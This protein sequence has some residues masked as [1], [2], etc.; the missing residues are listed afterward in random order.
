MIHPIAPDLWQVE[1]DLLMPGRLH[2]PCR[3]T[4][5]RLE[6][7][8]LL[9]LSP[10]RMDDKEAA[11]IAAIGPV[12]WIVAPNRMH[13]LWLGETRMRFPEAK[14]A[15]PP[16]LADK[17][18]DLHFDYVIQDG[19]GPWSPALEHVLIKGAP[20]VAE[21]VF[22]HRPSGTVLA[23]DLVMNIRRAR[24]AISPMVYRLAGTWGKLAQS[25]TWRLATR[26]RQL[27][28]GSVERIL[29]WQIHRVVPAH[30]D[31]VE[32]DA[33]ATLAAALRWMRSPRA[34]TGVH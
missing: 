6:D 16:G 13:H 7:S 25:R 1:T 5:V 30:G 21:V 18:P 8:S 14:L 11:A 15:G 31:V 4:I 3:M 17:R 23:T 10:V 19:H 33:A 9:L 12:S 26:D 28:A 27:A 34:A 29:E 24:T 2:M 22:Y 32:K 20:Q